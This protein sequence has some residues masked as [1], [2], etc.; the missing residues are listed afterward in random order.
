MNRDF[1]VE[2]MKES[3]KC[4]LKE[5][6]KS[7]LVKI[8]LGQDLHLESPKSS[9]TCQNQFEAKKKES[10]ANLD[11]KVE[12]MKAIQNCKLERVKG[13]IWRIR[14]EPKGQAGSNGSWQNSKFLW[15]SKSN[16]EQW[17][18]ITSVY[19]GIST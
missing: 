13:H 15:C 8:K 16:N 19:N 7:K 9:Q 17:Q 6:K 18:C 11:C 3:K 1:L 10:K 4:K 12:E 5:V 2:G 14:L